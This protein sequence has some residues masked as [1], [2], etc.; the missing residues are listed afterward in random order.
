[1]A[2]PRPSFVPAD[3]AQLALSV[4]LCAEAGVPVVPQG[5]NTSMVGGAT[6]SA[7]GSQLVVSLA[8]LN[9]LRGIDRLDLSMTVEAGV[10]LQAAQDM[11]A[12]E[13]CLLPLSISAEGSAQIGGVLATNAGGNNTVRYGNARDLV[14]GL[15]AVLPDGLGVERV[16]AGCARTIPATA[17]ASC[18][19]AAKARWASSPP[20]C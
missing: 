7:D 19:A 2:S 15:E 14:L 8:R 5:G 11:A 4:R 3:V 17:C 9:R 10:T 20:P 18:S 13:G 1:M 16:C 6:P 12:A